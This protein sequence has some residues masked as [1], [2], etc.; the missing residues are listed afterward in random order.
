MNSL[1]NDIIRLCGEMTALRDSRATVI[2]NLARGRSERRHAVS[3]MQ[4]SFRNALA[5]TAA[6]THV[7]LHEF[8]SVIKQKVTDLRQT[9]VGLQHE[10]QNDLAGAR[11]AWTGAAS[12]HPKARPE[13]VA[14]APER[15]RAP[16]AKAKKKKT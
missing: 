8:I 4:E 16:V 1:T 12:A 13:P 6:K 11:Q 5:E 15:P 2:H 9:I 14:Q 3:T 10:F 7:E